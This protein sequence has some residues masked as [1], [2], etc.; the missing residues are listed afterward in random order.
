MGCDSGLMLEPTL[1]FQKNW[2]FS[3]SATAI[4]CFAASTL[5]CM[6]GSGG[7]EDAAAGLTDGQITA[8]AALL[9]TPAGDEACDS[10][11]DV[12]C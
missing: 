7:A 6:A 2:I 8:A 12:D 11:F 5:L 3:E 10:A 9:C 1:P 4:A